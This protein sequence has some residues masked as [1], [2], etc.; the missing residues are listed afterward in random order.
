VRPRGLS[1]TAR[2]AIGY[3]ELLAVVEEGADLGEAL[4]ATIARTRVFAR[5]QRAWFRRDPRVEW[6]A[7]AEEALD[8]LVA[9]VQRLDASDE[10]GD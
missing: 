8:R 2:Q 5:R 10:M 6:Q 4:E 9:E 3:R 1:R 7:T